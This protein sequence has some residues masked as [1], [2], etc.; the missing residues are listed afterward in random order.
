MTGNGLSQGQSAVRACQE[1]LRRVCVLLPHLAG[2]AR[3]VRLQADGRVATIGVFASGR[4]VLNPEFILALAPL[5]QVFVLAHELLHL[6]LDTHGRGQGSNAQAVNIAH[7]LIINDILEEALRREPPAGGLRRCGA[8]QMALETLLADLR[9]RP[10]PR[11]SWQ[12]GG[13]RRPPPAHG[14]LGQALLERARDEIQ[15]GQ[16]A[17][18]FRALA[19]LHLPASDAQDAKPPPEDG[20]SLDVL[21]NTQERQWYP[22]ARPRTIA[23]QRVA[24]RAAAAKANSLCRLFDTLDQLEATSWGNQAG[25]YQATMD[26]L[27]HAYPPP[28]ELALQHRFDAQTATAR[29]FARPSRRGPDRPGAA[30]SP[31]RGVGP[32]PGA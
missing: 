29:S 28:W 6:A 12:W 21:S 26:A 1:A 13:S 24:I 30:G 16:P 20:P 25:D 5:D 19:G 8:R 9:T 15:R 4:L 17:P 27:R 10:L 23:R 11:D 32:A 7:D 22:E 2:L 3:Q 31:A 14:A 18:P